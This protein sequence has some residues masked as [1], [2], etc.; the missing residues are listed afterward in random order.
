MEENIDKNLDKE[1]RKRKKMISQAINEINSYS[2]KLI[3]NE[4]NAEQLRLD[5]IKYKTTINELNE[6]IKIYKSQIEEL[7]TTTE[8]QDREIKK[9][10][11]TVL[12]NDTD[13]ITLKSILELFVKEYGIDTVKEITKISKEKIKELMKNE[14]TEGD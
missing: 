5:E 9:L 8:K 13:I 14:E 2:Q 1:A 4:Q 11:K 7:E 6:Y 10:R 12:K 3:E